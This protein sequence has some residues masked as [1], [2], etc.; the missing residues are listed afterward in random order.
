[1]AEFFSPLS[2]VRHWFLGGH[3][4]INTHQHSP[5]ATP[6]CSRGRR[7][8]C[9]HRAS[10]FTIFQPPW[11]WISFPEK[12]PLPMRPSRIPPPEP[13]F[14][15]AEAHIHLISSV[16]LLH[17]KLITTVHLLPQ[18]LGA[19][20]P[21]PSSFPKMSLWVAISASKKHHQTTWVSEWL[22]SRRLSPSLCLPPAIALE[23]FLFRYCGWFFWK[24]PFTCSWSLVKSWLQTS[25]KFQ[26]P[27]NHLFVL[28]I[29][30]LQ[31]TAPLHRAYKGISGVCW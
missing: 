9:P 28:A 5:P 30:S 13:L 12:N 22:E 19:N 10:V 4:P 25:S 31:K 15:A 7:C 27:P 26:V 16:T 18:I 2:V 17:D 1:L 14:E 6:C 21:P 24:V 20:C 3:R 23:D 11:L 29:L 8:T